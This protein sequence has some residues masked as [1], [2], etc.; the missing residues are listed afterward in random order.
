MVLKTGKNRI[1]LS[2][3]TFCIVPTKTLTN[4]SGKDHV[5]LV[6]P[7]LRII[8]IYNLQ[9]YKY[10]QKLYILQLMFRVLNKC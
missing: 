5:E 2:K 7:E 6:F 1:Q 10:C 3:R 9:D 8:F 4:S